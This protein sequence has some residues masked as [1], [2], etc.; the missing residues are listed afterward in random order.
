MKFSVEEAASC[1]QVVK[2]EVEV[3]VQYSDRASCVLAAG[4]RKNKVVREVTLSG[5][6]KELVESVKRTLTMNTALTTV[7]VK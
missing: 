7:V 4:F 1:A 5:V 3:E 2:V 6:S